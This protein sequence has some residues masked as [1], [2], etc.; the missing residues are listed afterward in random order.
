MGKK[1]WGG[2][3]DS[4]T[5]NLVEKFTSS[6][7]T[8]KR[9]YSYDIAGSIAHCKMLAKQSI[10]TDEDANN[11]VKG[12]ERIKEEIE[13]GDFEYSD[14]LE[15]IHMHIEAKLTEYIG[16]AAKKLHTARSRNDQVVL[17]TRMYLK[18]QTEEL[19]KELAIL[20]KVLTDFAKNHI[21]TIMPGY[22][23]TQ[24]A[25]PVLLAHH[26]MAY[27][28][29]FSRDI[30][31]FRDCLKRID[32]MPLGTAAL[33]GT[34]Y[35]IDRNYVAELLGFAKVS[36]NSM[37]TVSDRDFI[38]EF[39]SCSSIC[40]IHLSRISEEFILWSSAEFDFIEIPDSF[41][42]GSSIMPQKKNP[43]ICELARGKTGRVI[44]NLVSLLTMTKALPL[45]YNRDMQEDKE[46]LFDTADTLSFC[47]KIYTAMIPNIEVK[48]GNMRKAAMSGYLNA[49]DMADYLASKGMP[50]RTA[51][52]CVGKAVSYAARKKKELHELTIEELKRFSDLIEEDIFEALMLE[53]MIERRVS[54]GSTSDKNV[55]ETIKRIENQRK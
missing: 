22:T 27:Y 15:D 40:M 23:H 21:D 24:R 41:A 10:I 11:I 25:Q 49:T 8:D 46:P 30:E 32:V 33:A 54:Y 48:K 3:F 43:D 4:E 53:A 1:A 42:T 19:V 44:G 52:E 55:S 6:I 7:K 29:M 18:E 47:I 12:L 9:L 50:F 31:R 37:D 38:I 45:S 16:D 2:R 28:E 13:K 20:N 26:M 14:K 51:H 5:D 35:P 34:T 17:D 39:L 36:D